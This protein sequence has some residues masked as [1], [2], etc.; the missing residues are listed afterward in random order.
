MLDARVCSAVNAV[1]MGPE[2]IGK[3]NIKKEN[4]HVLHVL[5]KGILYKQKYS[6]GI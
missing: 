1:R 5:E 6:S 2:D 4:T 3:I